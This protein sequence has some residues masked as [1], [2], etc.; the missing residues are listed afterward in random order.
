MIFYCRF[1]VQKSVRFAGAD[2][3]GRIELSKWRN[4]TLNF[5][6][7]PNSMHFARGVRV[8]HVHS[9]AVPR[10]CFCDGACVGICASKNSGNVRKIVIDGWL[11]TLAH[12]VVCMKK[13]W[14]WSASRRRPKIYKKVIVLGASEWL[15]CMSRFM[16]RAHEFPFDISHIS[17]TPLPRPIVNEIEQAHFR[18]IHSTEADSAFRTKS[19]I[20][21]VFT[22]SFYRKSSNRS[23]TKNTTNLSQTRL[24]Q[25]KWNEKY[26]HTAYVLRAIV[27]KR[28]ERNWT[29]TLNRDEERKKKQKL[30]LDK[31]K[32][33]RMCWEIWEAKRIAR[34]E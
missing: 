28:S 34:F 13:S 22:R 31:C 3:K 21:T 12:F 4:V 18:A 20:H 6:C 7:R 32:R 23:N 14:R 27:V 16:W 2:K 11:F 10:K 19:L 5:G 26:S 17:Y 9:N 15:A 24:M 30:F 8:S 29:V 1:F 25:W 33:E